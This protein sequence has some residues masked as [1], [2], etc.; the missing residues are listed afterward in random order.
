[1]TQPL[2]PLGILKTPQEHEAAQA[3]A[4]ALRPYSPADRAAVIRQLEKKFDVE[5]AKKEIEAIAADPKISANDKNRVAS[6][7]LAVADKEKSRL[8]ADLTHM[9][10]RKKELA[11]TLEAL[12]ALDLWFDKPPRL[13]LERNDCSRL[14]KLKEA[15]KAGNII[16]G[17]K[18][19]STGVVDGA[20]HIL[21]LEHTFV[22]KHDW[23]SAFSNAPDAIGEFRLPYD[24]CVFEF[25]L[26]GRTILLW[27]QQLDSKQSFTCFIEAQ[28]RWYC[29]PQEDER[30]EFMR[31]LWDQVRAICI[32]LDAEVATHS[33]IRAPHK[34][35]EKRLRDGKAPLVDFHIVDLARRH[36]VANPSGAAST[37]GHKRLHFR[38]GHWRHFETSKTWVKWCL[39]GNPDLGFIQKSYAL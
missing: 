11:V 28:D 19:D 7:I 24:Q 36:R 30:D 31:F 16:D 18:K 34:L 23:A 4:D 9:D 8:E 38:R 32:A 25:R 29:P 14:H 2:D 13:I 12:R 21:A 33:V 22:V 10:W 1:M 37:G 3:I 15:T 26:D 20:K 39:V 27:A 6:Q 35:N 5:L 17:E